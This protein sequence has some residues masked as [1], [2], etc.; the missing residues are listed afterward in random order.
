LIDYV[1]R[2][3]STFI[4]CPRDPLLT[5]GIRLPIIVLQLKNIG[6]YTSFDIQVSAAGTLRPLVNI[7]IIEDT[8][9]HI[10][11]TIQS[12]IVHEV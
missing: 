2:E 4:A 1:R 10:L 5:L 6:K 9:R 11:I 7:I 3:R 12:E 8:Q